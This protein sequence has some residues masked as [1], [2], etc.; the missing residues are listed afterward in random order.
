MQVALK[1]LMAI[2]PFL[3]GIG[4]LAPLLVQVMEATGRDAPFGMD[5]V[6]F[7]LAIGAGWGLVANIRGRWL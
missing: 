2:M 6:A 5:R 1:K 7:G 4:F 3:F